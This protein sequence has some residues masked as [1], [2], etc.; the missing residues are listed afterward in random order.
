M[1][2]SRVGVLLIAALVSP[3]L[4]PPALAAPDEAAYGAGQNYPR[5][6]RGRPMAR[7]EIVGTLSAYDQVFPAREM[8]GGGAVR[9][10]PAHAAKP[11]WPFVDEYLASHPATGLLVLKDGQ[12]LVE[13]YQYGR[14]PET[15]FTSFSMAK[16]L[17]GMAVGIA[18]AEGKI[19]SIDDPVERYEPAL[20]ETPWQGVPIRHVLNMASGVAFDETYDKP[21]TDIARL[22]AAWAAP[23]AGSLLQAL[24]RVKGNEAKPGERFKYISADTQVLGQVLVKATGQTLTDYVSQKIWAPMG[25]EADGSWIIDAQG[26]E[27]AYCCAQARLRDWGRFG[28][29]LLE[30]GQREGRSLIP[31][32]WVE[33]GTTVR[34][35]DGHLQPR[36][37]TPYFGYGYQTWVFPDHLGFALQGVRGQAVFVHPRLKLVMVQTAAWP[38]SSVPE[39][40]RQ[41]DQ[42]WREL[43][44]RAGRL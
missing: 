7:H 26:M 23:A 6:E 3:A 20:A 33:A 24:G 2:A 19:A 8:R 35:R 25:A 31:K 5:V 39:L 43:V 36:R 4:M 17:V 1:T 9:A 15:R 21:G 41:R 29:L 34:F 28:Q 42:F 27:A 14:T 37:A 32:D 12:V 38:A 18:I 13:R 10:L 22:S 30:G 40:G 16:T 11:D 44:L